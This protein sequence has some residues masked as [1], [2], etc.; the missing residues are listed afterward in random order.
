M[1]LHLA[2]WEQGQHFTAIFKY[3]LRDHDFFPLEN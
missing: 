3:T 1:F 2:D